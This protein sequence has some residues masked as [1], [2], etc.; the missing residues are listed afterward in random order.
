[1]LKFEKTSVAKRLNKKLIL[2]GVC[3]KPDATYKKYNFIV[4]NFVAMHMYLS[5]TYLLP[6]TISPFCKYATDHT[7]WAGNVMVCWHSPPSHILI[8]RSS[9]DVT[10]L[11]T[12][13]PGRTL[14]LEPNNVSVHINSNQFNSIKYFLLRCCIESHTANNR[15]SMTYIY[16]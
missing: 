2:Y 4:S 13:T 16:K 7:L 1:M 12:P 8:V 9:P 14:M 15:N 5:G 11:S 10:K 3:N 6:A